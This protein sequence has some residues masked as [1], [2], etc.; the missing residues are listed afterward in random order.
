M[1]AKFVKDTLFEFE[2]GQDPRHSMGIGEAVKINKWFDENFGSNSWD[3][4]PEYRI[5]RDGTV[6]INGDFYLPWRVDSIPEFIKFG[7]IDGDFKV[8]RK[9]EIQNL[10][11]FPRVINGDLEFFENGIKPTKED[12]LSI[13]DI[14]GDIELESEAQKRARLSRKRMKERG[15]LASRTEHDLR[16]YPTKPSQYGPKF[17]RGY[18]LYQVLKAI[19]AAGEEGLRNNEIRK[20]LKELTYGPGSFDPVED[21]GWGSWY[22]S[23]P[24]GRGL[25]DKTTKIE[26]G[27][28]VLSPGGKR[29]LEEYEDIFED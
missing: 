10:D 17:S 11:W 28:Y 7:T 9:K 21:R 15:P 14:N 6:D 24:G 16:K 13:S 22:F 19:E 26:R 1:K 20:I 23:G 12:L 25:Q 2:K 3:K 27:R 8:T 18:K 5:N 29:Y 4:A